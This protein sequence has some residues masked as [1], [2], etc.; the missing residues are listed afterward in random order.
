MLLQMQQ[1]FRLMRNSLV[2]LLILL[3]PPMH[4]SWIPQHT[5]SEGRRQ[6]AQLA[7][8]LQRSVPSSCPFPQSPIV[9]LAVQAMFQINRESISPRV[10]WL[11]LE[12]MAHPT[13]RHL[14]CV[15]DA[16]P[17]SIRCTCTGTARFPDCTGRVDGG[18]GHRG[19]V[20]PHL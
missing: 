10:S 3:R 19:Y 8:Q 2:F 18:G 1:L 6:R 17:V 7:L 16:R 15:T 4:P 9:D 5:K 13:D 12:H 11:A 20:A 14:L